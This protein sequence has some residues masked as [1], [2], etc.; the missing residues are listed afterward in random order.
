MNKSFKASTGAT[1]FGPGKATYLLPLAVIAFI[2]IFSEAGLAQDTLSKTLSKQSDI[3]ATRQRRTSSESNDAVITF[4][5]KQEV[6]RKAGRRVFVRSSSLLVR[7]AVVEEKLLKQP[8]FQQLGF[9][10]TREL[11]EAD[12]ILELRHDLF[13]LYVFTVV[14]AKAGLVLAG[15]KLSSLGGTVADKVAKRFV[16]KMAQLSGP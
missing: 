4:D 1:Q 3:A 5:A 6:L 12:L 8:Q 14:D 10:I 7:G 13:T 15:G 9:L 11:S 16:K 2:A